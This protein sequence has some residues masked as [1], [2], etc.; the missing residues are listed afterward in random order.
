M[1]TLLIGQFVYPIGS[2]E[3]GKRIGSIVIFKVSKR[4]NHLLQSTKGVIFV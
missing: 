4:L 3:M 1:R 2:K